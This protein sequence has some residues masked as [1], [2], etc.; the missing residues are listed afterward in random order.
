MIAEF[1]RSCLLLSL[2]EVHTQAFSEAKHF[3]EVACVSPCFSD[4]EVKKIICNT[5]LDSTD[6]KRCVLGA[7]IVIL[8]DVS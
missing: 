2:L 8:S 5:C 1:Y 3:L 7:D 6:D 4:S